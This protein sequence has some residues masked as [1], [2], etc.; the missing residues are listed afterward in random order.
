MKRWDIVKLAGESPIGIE[1][2]VAEGIFSE[3]VLRHTDVAHWYSVD[4]WAGDRGHDDS[5]RARATRRLSNYQDR[6]TIIW[7]KFE[8]IRPKFSDN[9]FDIIYVDGYAHTGQEGGKTLTDW[10]PKLKPG[11]IMAGD[12][13]DPAWPQTQRC[14]DQFVKQK[15]LTLTVFKFDNSE[16]DPWSMHPSWWVR[17][18]MYNPR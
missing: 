1:L 4:M 2:G 5:Q 9:Y 17:K 12:D 16:S 11:G 13:Y 18:P 7:S 3:N 8:D 15:Q 14:V 6:N 10:W